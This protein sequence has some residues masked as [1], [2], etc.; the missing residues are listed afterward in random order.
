MKP[1]PQSYTPI[2]RCIKVHGVQGEVAIR[3]SSEQFIDLD[4]D[5]IFVEVEGSNVPFYVEN[6]RGTSDYL[7]IKFSNIDNQDKAKRFIGLK[8]LVDS[9]LLDV[10]TG[11]YEQDLKS[12]AEFLDGFTIYSEEKKIGT[13]SNFLN[14]PN[15]PLF[16]IKPISPSQDSFYIPVVDSWIKS[17]DQRMKRIEM[18]LPEGLIDGQ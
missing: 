3:L 2:G 18:D 16:E 7:I 10:N 15:N 8:F 14:I 12:L 6:V 13:I 5:Y 9:S 11:L 1:L 17:I 4:F